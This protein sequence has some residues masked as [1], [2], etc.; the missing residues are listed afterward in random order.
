M[1]DLPLQRFR[2]GCLFGVFEQLWRYVSDQAYAA[3]DS[4]YIQDQLY[5]NVWHLPGLVIT[6]PGSSVHFYFMKVI[7]HS[8]VL[9]MTEPSAMPATVSINTCCLTVTQLMAM[10]AMYPNPS[11]V[12]MVGTVETVNPI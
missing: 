3:I 9:N 11:H 12:P 4:K 5:G 1:I 10:M 2:F 6:S 8:L 7:S